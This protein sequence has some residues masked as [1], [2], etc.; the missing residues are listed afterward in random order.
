MSMNL[1]VEATRK[2]TVKVKGRRKIIMDRVS[3]NLWQT[4]TEV[5]R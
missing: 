4:P 2:A 1:Y 3:F 5:T